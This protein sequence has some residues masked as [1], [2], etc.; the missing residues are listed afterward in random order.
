MNGNQNQ[1]EIFT[2]KLLNN[3]SIYVNHNFAKIYG[4]EMAVFM[5]ELI[6]KFNFAREEN[7]LDKDGYFNVTQKEI[8]IF[9]QLNFNKQTKIISKLKALEI[10][11]V[12]KIGLPAKNWYK[13]DIDKLLELYSNEEN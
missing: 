4:F 13:I 12:K 1:I 7:K 9:T 6:N 5:G 2:E 3:D 8:R 10:L 11:K